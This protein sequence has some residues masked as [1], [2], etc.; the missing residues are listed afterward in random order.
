MNTSS[1]SWLYLLMLLPGLSKELRNNA[2][3]KIIDMAELLEKLGAFLNEGML[4]KLMPR[5]Q[6]AII[7]HD[8]LKNSFGEIFSSI[9][10]VFNT[11]K[12]T[13]RAHAEMIATKIEPN[14]NMR[15]W[16]MFGFLFQL[17]FL[18]V[19]AYADTVQVV[20]NLAPLFGQ[21]VAN[22]PS[23]FHN[24]TVS[25]V[26]SSVGI[27][28]A[29]GFILAE[30][31]GLTHFGGWNELTGILRKVVLVIL[32]FSLISTLIIDALLALSRIRTIPEVAQVLSVEASNQIL[33]ISATASTLVIVPMFLTTL[34]FLQ[35]FVGFAIIYIVIIY[36]LALVVE[37]LQLA[38]IGVIWILTYG[39]A[40]VVQFIA[41]ILLWILVAIVY[42][43]GWTFAATGITLVKLLE[44]VQ[45]ILNIGY[46]PLDT[47]TNWIK[48]LFSWITQRYAAV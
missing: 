27:A 43:V 22:V 15:P 31:G 19:F 8:L 5:T 4:D 38:F 6:G 46:L 30:F 40:Y 3:E 39:V 44:L 48:Q 41:R 32:W 18:A 17:I 16:R 24:L 33:L 7:S 36:L 47:I 34:L 2:I 28:I 11:T 14:E 42:I 45:A 20:S 21:D 12:G 35:G 37:L 1:N 25:L 9:S 26:M 23:I 10:N 29:A 13:I